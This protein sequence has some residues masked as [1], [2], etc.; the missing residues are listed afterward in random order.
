M[1]VQDKYALNVRIINY[2]HYGNI[3]IFDYFCI[4]SVVGVSQYL[5][6]K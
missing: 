3:N 2:I 6:N 5:M 4:I 1:Y